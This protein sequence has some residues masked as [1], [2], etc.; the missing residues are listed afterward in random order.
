MQWRDRFETCLSVSN[1]HDEAPF[2]QRRKLENV[3]FTSPLL[4][5]CEGGD[6]EV[7]VLVEATLHYVS[8]YLRKSI[9]AV[10]AQAE[11]KK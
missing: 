2:L 11:I 10:L 4:P 5:P 3:D 1:H 8:V 9:S 7:V 6:K